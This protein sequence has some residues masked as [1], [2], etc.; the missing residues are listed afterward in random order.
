MENATKALMIA[1]GVLIGIL[2]LSLG[3]YLYYALG[4]YM[5]STQE[6]LEANAKNK[7]NTQFLKYINVSGGSTDPD[8]ELTIQDVITA[9]NL[10]NQNNIQH[11]LTADAGAN[12]YYV[13]V[14]AKIN[15]IEWKYNLEVD[16]KDRAVELLEKAANYAGETG[17]DYYTYECRSEDIVFS[18]VTGRVIEIT[19]E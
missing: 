1:A 15:G 11:G 6:Q 13:T 2:I 8:H 3:V 5:T 10:A 7:F 9:A 17:N 18:N 14:N 4:G 16:I 12:S 19:F